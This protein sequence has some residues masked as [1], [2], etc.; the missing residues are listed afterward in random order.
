MNESA[1]IEVVSE[2]SKVAVRNIYISPDHNFFGHHGGPAGKSPVTEVEQIE[3]V[4]GRGIRGD[5]FFDY[6]ENYKG[7][8]T[9]FAFEVYEQ[10][11]DRLNRFDKAPSV[12][13]RNVI[14]EGMDLNGLIGGEFEI[15]GVRFFGTEECK[16][17][18][19]MDEAFAPGAEEFLRGRGGLRAVILSNGKLR[20]NPG[21]MTFS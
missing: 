5:R 7:Q 4:A 1:I 14:T 18:Y 16:P 8:I 10:L 13:R 3:C 19:W 17:C 21:R 9:F 12:F 11:R 15:Q 20:T 2:I 6:R